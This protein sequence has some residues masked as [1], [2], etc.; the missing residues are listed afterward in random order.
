MYDLCGCTPLRFFLDENSFPF[1]GLTGIGKTKILE[2]LKEDGEQVIDLEMLA[3][4]KGS[5]LGLWHGET[6]PTQKYWES[7]LAKEMRVFSSNR[8]VWVE[9]ESR[10]IGNVTIPECLFEVLC[11][12][13]RVIINLP[14][15]E[16]VKHILRDY[17]NWLQDKDFLKKTLVKLIRVQGHKQVN[18]WMCLIDQGKMDVFVES[19]LTEHYDPAY[20]LSQ[21]K[22]N[23]N[24]ENT[25]SLDIP[26]LEKDS[27]KKLV[28]HLKTL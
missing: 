5:V 6:Q 18:K 24:K 7:L 25:E 19:I 26:N 15:E 12:S 16:R 21:K 11:D 10:R 1:S 13:P 27:L 28:K 22:N 2:T 4:H 17:P 9:S 23:Y 3:K 20:T 8:T 14:L